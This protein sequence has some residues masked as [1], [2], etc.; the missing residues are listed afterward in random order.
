[1]ATTQTLLSVRFGSSTDLRAADL[2]FDPRLSLA[3]PVQDW[4]LNPNQLRELLEINA[5]EVYQ[6]ATEPPNGSWFLI[7]N[8]VPT[9]PFVPVGGGGINGPCIIPIEAEVTLRSGGVSHKFVVDAF[10]SACLPIPSPSVSV[11]VRW[12]RFAESNTGSAW[13]IPETVKVFGTLQRAELTPRAYFNYIWHGGNPA[14]ASTRNMI[15]PPFATGFMARGQGIQ[16]LGS[17]APFDPATIWSAQAGLVSVGPFPLIFLTGDM[18]QVF[19]GMTG[20]PAYWDLPSMCQ[21]M[22]AQ[23]VAGE[24]LPWVGEYK[25]VI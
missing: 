14:G 7:L 25:L 15:N 8:C 9:G 20:T 13:Q 3:N 6:N 21:S 12:K 1:M 10:P 19:A 11:S 4:T 17:S 22:L 24:G 23:L 2:I 5:N 18:W 16:L